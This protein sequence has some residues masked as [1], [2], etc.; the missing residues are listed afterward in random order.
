MGRRPSE[1]GRHLPKAG[2]SAIIA[3]GATRREGV[4][5][6]DFILAMPPAVG[7][8]R[9]RSEKLAVSE[10]GAPDRPS[11]GRVRGVRR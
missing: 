4:T 10:R 6:D 2:P 9:R 1:G 5:P 7:K 11:L 3:A 8:R